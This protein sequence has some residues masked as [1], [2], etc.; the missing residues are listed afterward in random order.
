MCKIVS[1][2]WLFLLSVLLVACTNEET[3]V[4]DKWEDMTADE[5]VIPE[6]FV[7]DTIV[8]RNLFD[9][10]QF[11]DPLMIDLLAE[12]RIC[13]TAANAPF[14]IHKPP[15]QPRFYKFFKY[16]KNMDWNDGFALEIRS[17]VEDFPVR[18]FIIF[19]RIE[20]KLAKVQGFVANL[21]EQHT[22]PT[23]YYDLMLLF[24][25]EEAGSFV[26]KYRW[27]KN[28]YE[29]KSVEA[30]DGYLVKKDRKDS[31]SDVVSKRLVNNNMFF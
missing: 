2:F 10:L 14:D 27:Q 12:L 20:G 5:V 6:D 4:I 16:N 30:I 8:I 7:Q 23:G 18:R 25:D 24:R 22:T 3:A 21:V 28:K 1:Y 31:L 15:C 26:V 29:F 13:D 19:E 9:E 17:G 11:A